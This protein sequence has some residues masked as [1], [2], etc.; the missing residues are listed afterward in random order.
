MGCK[1]FPA[2][3]NTVSELQ[4]MQRKAESRASVRLPNRDP[5]AAH[6][7]ILTWVPPGC[8]LAPLPAGAGERTP[9]PP[10]RAARRAAPLF[11]TGVFLE[12]TAQD[13]GE[14]FGRL[15]CAVAAAGPGSS[16]VDGVARRKAPLLR[17]S[18]P[19]STACIRAESPSPT[20]DISLSATARFC[21]VCYQGCS[22]SK[23]RQQLPLLF[24]NINTSCFFWSQIAICFVVLCGIQIK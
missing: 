17:A 2:T 15:Q 3:K 21:S 4:R 13:Q 14:G 1:H 20:R 6:W 24:H 5:T 23:C 19:R 8:P 18:D 7:S 22:T 10:G 11:Y 16:L 12:R 9:R